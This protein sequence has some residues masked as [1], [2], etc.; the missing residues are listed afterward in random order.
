MESFKVLFSAQSAIVLYILI[1]VFLRKR[2]IITTETRQSFINFVIKVALPCMIMNSFLKEMTAQQL[3]D[4]ALVLALSSAVCIFA[5]GAGILLYRGF[6]AERR[7]VMKFSLLVGN[8][9]FAGLPLVA[10]IYGQEALFYGSFY[11]I[12]NVVFNWSVGIAF[13]TAADF[14]GQVKNVLTNPGIIAVCLGIIRTLLGIKLPQAVVTVIGGLGGI[15]A[16]LGI[17]LMGTILAECDIKSVFSRD[18]I[19]AT[20]MKLLALPA[21]TALALTFGQRAG[22]WN[23]SP[24]AYGV[25]VVITGMP[26]GVTTPIL[27][28]K[29]GQDHIFASQVVFLTTVMSLATLPLIVMLL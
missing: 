2:G 23:L 19:Y 4:G 15:T 18:V 13:L 29:Y 16:P 3:R 12:S 8:V 1:G 26:A 10:S 7:S 28:E 24:L 20:T 5:W 22:L 9:G 14:K 27:A 11:L 21:V 17:I 25:L 6:P